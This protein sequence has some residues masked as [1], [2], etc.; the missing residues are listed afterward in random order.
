M[1]F[2][3]NRGNILIYVLFLLTVIAALILRYNKEI[4]LN[5]FVKNNYYKNEIEI[6]TLENLVTLIGIGYYS[7]DYEYADIKEMENVPKNVDYKGKTYKVFITKESELL[8]I[9]SA[10]RGTIVNVLYEI[11][12]DFDEE[13]ID[14]VADNILDWKDEDDLVRANGAEKDQYTYD[15]MPYDKGFEFIEDLKLVKN[16]EGRVYFNQV[17]DNESPYDGLFFRFSVWGNNARIFNADNNRYDV[18][19][20]VIRVYIKTPDNRFY[21]FFVGRNEHITPFHYV[22]LD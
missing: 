10:D 16:I 6:L 13:K 22:R 9:N 4:K 18:Y 7:G 20:D 21:V 17:S 14:I 19:N 1:R 12:G 5:L 2:R 8:D 3:D 15:N 11:L